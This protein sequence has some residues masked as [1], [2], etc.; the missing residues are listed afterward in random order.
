M[1]RQPCDGGL[2]QFFFSICSSAYNMATHIPSMRVAPLADQAMAVGTDHVLR[3]NFRSGGPVSIKD[4]LAPSHPVEH[5]QVTHDARQREIQW[6]MLELTQGS[7]AP[8]R[9]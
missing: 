7:V 4:T 1:G 3:D 8:R 9:L 5:I 2:E 6:K